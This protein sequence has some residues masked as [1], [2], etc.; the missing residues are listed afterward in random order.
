M[1]GDQ[2]LIALRNNAVTNITNGLPH[3]FSSPLKKAFEINLAIKWQNLKKLLSQKCWTE[4]LCLEKPMYTSAH[5]SC[6]NNGKTYSLLRWKQ[7]TYISLILTF[8]SEFYCSNFNCE[9]IH[10]TV[11]K[12]WFN[13]TVMCTCHQKKIKYFYDHGMKSFKLTQGKVIYK[14]QENIQQYCSYIAIHPMQ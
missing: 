7:I 1:M 9:C 3:L 4:V 8:S 12:V 6:N 5:W 11:I 2:F 14:Q 13:S 10:T